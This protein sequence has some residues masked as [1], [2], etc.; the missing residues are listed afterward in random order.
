MTDKH[1]FS[2]ADDALPLAGLRVLDLSQGIAGPYCGLMLRQQGAQVTKVEPPQGDWSRHMGRSKDGRSAIFMA[3]NAGKQGMCLDA[4]TPEGRAQLQRLAAEADVVLQ[5]YRPGV[6][7]RMGVG[8]E[9]LSA[10]K[11]SLV[12][13]SISGWGRSGPMAHVP[14]LDTTMQAASGMMHANRGEDGKPRRIGV[15]VVDYATGM[16][17]AQATLA[18]VLRQV[19]TGRGRHVEVAMLQA[20]AVLQ[21][22][23]TIDAAMF[24]QQQGGAINAPT[25]LF[26]TRDGRYIYVSMLNDAM[27]LRLARALQMDGWIADASLHASSG[28]LPRAQELNDALAARLA[29]D[30][31]AHWSELLARHDILF[32]PARSPGELPQDPQVQHLKV[33]AEHEVPGVGTVPLAGL[34]GS[35]GQLPLAPAPRLG[36]HNAEMLGGL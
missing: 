16:Y 4:A 24:P 2:D 18:A 17:A 11:P 7:E 34:P 10:R 32:A 25:G 14:T 3:C 13:V 29:Q 36:Q 30:T 35:E 5:N 28:R 26:E 12:Y 33:F 31:L 9:E 22:Y 23:L 15:Y 1:L 27:F 19:R 21:N 8:W 6:A 20:A